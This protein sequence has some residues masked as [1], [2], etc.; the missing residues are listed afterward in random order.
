MAPH[1]QQFE[2]ASPATITDDLDSELTIKT[3]GGR[4]APAPCKTLQIH[5]APAGLIL[6]R[7]AKTATTEKQRQRTRVSAP[8]ELR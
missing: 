8:H 2:V 7:R 1:D 6:L 3:L 4:G 5:G